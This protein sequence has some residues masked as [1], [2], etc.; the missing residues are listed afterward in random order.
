MSD[1]LWINELLDLVD[2]ALF[3]LPG[4]PG[5]CDRRW[6]RWTSRRLRRQFDSLLRAL[7]ALRRDLNQAERERSGPL[8][9]RMFA[10]R[11][12]AEVLP[13][14]ALPVAA[15]YQRYLEAWLTGLSSAET[16]ALCAY[17]SVGAEALAWRLTVWAKEV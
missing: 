7:A 2:A 1:H 9:Y 10:Q 16:A 17:F 4:V 11:L 12:L 15:D 8:A 13:A 6:A 3:F 5:R 14:A